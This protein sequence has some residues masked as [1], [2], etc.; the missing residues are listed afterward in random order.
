MTDSRWILCWILA[1]NLEAQRLTEPKA[2]FRKIE[3]WLRKDRDMSNPT[4]SSILN[5]FCSGA[6]LVFRFPVVI[7]GSLDKL[8]KLY[9]L[10]YLD[11]ETSNLHS[12]WTNVTQN[13]RYSGASQ[14]VGLHPRGFNFFYS[15]LKSKTSL[16]LDSTDKNSKIFIL[17]VWTLRHIKFTWIRVKWA[18]SELSMWF[19][20]GDISV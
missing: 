7:Y 6:L 14:I 13:G 12:A 10:A 18:I 9:L 11:R 15:K 2:K 8:C 19:H 20:S 16:L 5:N 17:Q 4:K 1:S 3:K